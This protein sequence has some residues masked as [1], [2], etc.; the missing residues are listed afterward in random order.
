MKTIIRL[1]LISMLLL[2][3]APA[4]SGSALHVFSCQ[5]DEEA[6]EAQIEAVAS[7][8]LKAAKSMKGG[9]NLEV[10]VS[11]PTAAD[12][13]ENDFMFIMIAPNFAEWG[14]FMDGYKGSPASK[15][16]PQMGDLA[17]CPDSS[18]WES[19]KME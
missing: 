8:W 10:Y 3:A 19:E 16:D 7:A 18:L 5:Q 13:G 9:E 14:V 1:V 17:D 4:Y 15:V 12:M 6:T 11:W 2:I